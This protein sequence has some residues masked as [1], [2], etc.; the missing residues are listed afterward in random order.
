MRVSQD[1]KQKKD[2]GRVTVVKARQAAKKSKPGPKVV[3]AKNLKHGGKFYPKGTLTK[4]M[5][6]EA[7]KVCKKAGYLE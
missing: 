3:L 1:V 4:D 5:P 2:S 6:E 7:V